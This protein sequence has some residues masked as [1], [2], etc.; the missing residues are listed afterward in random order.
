[1][2]G[3]DPADIFSQVFGKTIFCVSHVVVV[4]KLLFIHKVE[5]LVDL[6]VSKDK[7]NQP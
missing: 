4:E 1:M 3:M 7:E 6:E 2:G 5:V